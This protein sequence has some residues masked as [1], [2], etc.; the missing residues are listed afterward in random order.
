MT[1]R[2][3]LAAATAAMQ[4]NGADCDSL[5]PKPPPIRRLSTCTRL[6]SSFSAC[7]TRCCISLGCWVEQ[8]TMHAA[9]L[10]R[11]RITDLPFEVELLLA[12]DFER[13]F[14]RARCCAECGANRCGSIIG[15]DIAGPLAAHQVHRRQHIAGCRMGLAR[16][17]QRRQRL[18]RNRRFGQCGGAA[19][20]IARLCHHRE[21]RLAEVAQ[22]A[23]GQDRLVVDDRAAVVGARECR[24]QSAPR[25]R[26]AS[27]ESHRATDRSAAHGPPATG[28][29]RNAACRRAREYRR[30]T[31]PGQP[32]AGGPIHAGG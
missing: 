29:A 32:R 6:A 28:R 19:G 16:V 1:G 30:H 12:A 9:V 11:N 21:H 20:D 31:A 8:W 15:A 23:V 4:A 25:P 26:P 7:A 2:C 10:A 13:A 22:F 17:E 14:Q 3:S 24:Q 27:R 5:P 18:E